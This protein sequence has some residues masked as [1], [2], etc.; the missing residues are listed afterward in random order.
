MS[1]TFIAITAQPLQGTLHLKLH[2][3][4]SKSVPRHSKATHCFGSHFHDCGV[5]GGQQVTQV[6]GKSAESGGISALHANQAHC[7]EQEDIV[8]K[9]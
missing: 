4:R 6:I 5:T 2:I 7:E 9:E 3:L 8:S 1:T